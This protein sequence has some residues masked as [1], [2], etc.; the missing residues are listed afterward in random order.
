MD[1]GSNLSIP[2]YSRIS[3]AISNSKCSSTE[4]ESLPGGRYRLR[5]YFDLL[6]QHGPQCGLVA[7]VNGLR[8]LG[9]DRYTVDTVFVA[10]KE[11][12][13]TNNGEMFSPFWLA[14]LANI[15]CETIQA[16]VIE[17]PSTKRLIQITNC[18]AEAILI[19][20]D[21][22]KNGEPGF[23][24]GTKSHWCL[25]VGALTVSATF[26]GLK[27]SATVPYNEDACEAFVFGIQGK[28]RYPGVWS[29]EALCRSNA[30]LRELGTVRASEELVYRLP[31]NGVS[32]LSGKCVL[33]Q[34][35]N[36][37]IC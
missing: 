24:S 34:R 32:E 14:D 19:P 18:D 27:E 23:H 2:L 30:Q 16:K 7:L 11:C 20:Y 9:E 8:M 1:S 17:F 13:F 4:D 36:S 37:I 12:E 22:E 5:L 31:E 15:V 26:K 10:A 33:L 35:R 6:L 29:I 25:C 21:C 3:F 28:S